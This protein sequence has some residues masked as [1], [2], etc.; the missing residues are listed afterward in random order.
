MLVAKQLMSSPSRA[1]QEN[2]LSALQDAKN[3]L[4]YLSHNDWTLIIDRA[5][6]LTLKKNELL[7]QQGKSSKTLYLIAAGRISV[8][9]AGVPLARL[10]PGETCG[11]MS[12]LEDSVAS[13]TAVAEEEVQAFAIEWQ[14]LSNLFELFP[15]LASRFYRSLALN[16][17]RRLREQIALSK[18]K[19]KQPEM[20]TD[21]RK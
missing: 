2:L 14:T 3:R 10:G 16:L 13:A 7:M 8:T 21:D 15:H 17:S 9:V 19:D 11:E 4:Q 1:A 5:K 6:H 20:K 12:F 18:R